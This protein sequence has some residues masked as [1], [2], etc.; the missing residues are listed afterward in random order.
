M[1]Q[2]RCSLTIEKKQAHKLAHLDRMMEKEILSTSRW[3]TILVQ[4]YQL[5]DLLIKHKIDHIHFLSIDTEGGEF[6]ILSISGS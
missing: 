4:C 1:D 2:A 5:N 6:D 3:E